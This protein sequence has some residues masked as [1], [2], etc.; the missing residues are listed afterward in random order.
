M[1]TAPPSRGFENPRGGG[2]WGPPAH[3]LGSRVNGC[4]AAE[5]PRPRCVP[6]MAGKAWKWHLL[7]GSMGCPSVAEC[8]GMFSPYK[9]PEG[10]KETCSPG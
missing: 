3:T 1:I 4:E 8:C 7:Y 5:F 6:R 9:E 2:A 10:R